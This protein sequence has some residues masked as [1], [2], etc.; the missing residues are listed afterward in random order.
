V[1]TLIQIWWTSLVLVSV[2]NV[3]LW[4]ATALR[5]R[6]ERATVS[7]R[8]FRSRA[9]QVGLSAV[10]VLVCGFRSALPRADVQRICLVDSWLSSVA[11]GRT[12]ATVAELCFAVQWALLVRELGRAA[13]SR[14]AAAISCLLV[15]LI[16][17]AELASWY[18]VITTNFLGN[19]VEQSTW[20]LCGLL[21]LASCAIMWR[22]SGAAARRVM[23]V[24]SGIIGCFVL[25]MTTVDV[26]GYYARW[27]ADQAGG[28]DYLGW[29]EGPVDAAGRWIVTG[30]LEAWEGELAWMALYF[31][32]GVWTSIWM[33]RVRPARGFG[34]DEQ[35]SRAGS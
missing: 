13:R 20:T 31:S 19:V 29:S 26:P 17:F 22:R 35:I 3:G 12:L 2:I 23:A 27:R 7:Q 6:R 21:I 14:A 15:P 25:F 10:Y 28:K 8:T 33:G 5:L 32:V 30:S 11:L 18:A 24:C 4:L 16:A 1:S 34:G 9:T